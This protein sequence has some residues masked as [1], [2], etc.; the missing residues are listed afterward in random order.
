MFNAAADAM[1]F[2]LIWFVALCVMA[3]APSVPVLV[4]L[5][6]PLVVMPLWW[7]WRRIAP[8]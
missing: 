8:R 3:V 7:L 6:T 4:F 2:A 1:L 5:A